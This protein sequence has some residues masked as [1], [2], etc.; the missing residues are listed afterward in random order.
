MGRK[1]RKWAAALAFL[2]L[3]CGCTSGPAPAVS[4]A[5]IDSGVLAQKI[6]DFIASQVPEMDTVRAVLVVVDGQSKLEHY[7]HGFGAS[8]HEHVHSVTKSVLSALIGIAIGEGLISGL[9]DPLRELLPEYRSKMDASAARITLRQLMDHSG[10]FVDGPAMFGVTQEVLAGRRDLVAW[11]LSEGPTKT[12]GT[13]V[14]YSNVGAHLVSAVLYSALQR[15]GS[16]KGQSVLDYA[17][18]KLFDPLGIDT[19]PRVEGRINIEL[20]VDF[21]GPGFGWARLGKLEWGAGGLRLTAPDMAKFGQLFLNDGVWD[22]NR[23]LPQGWVAEVS[24]PS[25]LDPAYGLLWRRA[26]E[27]WPC[28]VG[29]GGQRIYVIPDRRALIVTLT[30][31]KTSNYPLDEVDELVGQVVVPALG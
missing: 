14:V 11:A 17:R 24:A 5:G 19:R 16:T 7:R 27:G 10:G 25:R 23:L 18:T 6:E 20:D 15:H 13:E 29:W 3:I 4:P 30:D 28:A 26:R 21:A 31:T 22:G 1:T 2:L 9:D 8:D 12:P